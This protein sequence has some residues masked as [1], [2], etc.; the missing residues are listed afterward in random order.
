MTI[1]RVVC[2]LN[3]PD[4]C[5]MLVDIDGGHIKS[6][7]GDP[8][9]PVTRGVVCTKLTHYSSVA[10]SPER[11]KTPQKRAGPKGSGRFVPISWNEAADLICDQIRAVS[12]EYT[13][14]SILP[15]TYT[16]TMGI[17]NRYALDRFFHAINASRLQRSICVDGAYA[18]WNVTIGKVI[19]TDCSR[20]KD[21]DL[22]VL[23]GI[24]AMST[25][26]HIMPFVSAARAKGARLIVIDPYRNRTAAV[27]DQHIKIRPGT[28]AA[29]ALGVMHVLI[30]ENLID[31]NYIVQ[32]TLGFEELGRRIEEYPPSR[33]SKITGMTA[34]EIVDFAR[35]YGR[36]RAPFL[37]I[38][39]GLSRN[40]N[41]GM[42]VRTIACLPGLVGAFQKPGGGCFLASGG[43][44]EL[45]TEKLQRPDLLMKQ[46]RIVNMVQL[47]RALTELDPPIKLLYVC[48]SNP[49]TIAPN[50]VKILN[51]LAREDLF[52]VVHDQFL[53][54]TARFADV[55]LPAPTFLEYTDW[56]R[57]YGHYYIQKSPA[58]MA[59]QGD[60]KTNWEA[61]SFLAEKLGLTEPALFESPEEIMQGCLRPE[62]QFMRGITMEALERGGPVRAQI[63]MEGDPFAN[64]FFTPSGKMEFYSRSL[65]DRGMDPL[66]AHIPT[67]E[68]L[69]N[70]AL[71]ERYPLHLLTPPSHFFLNSQCVVGAYHRRH[72]G[73][74]TVKITSEDADARGVKNGDLV[75]VYNERGEC[76]LYAEVTDSVQ[77][78]VVVAEAGWWGSFSPGGKSV[79][80]LTTDELTDLG[81]SAAFH[82]G[83]VELEIA[84][85]TGR[86]HVED[87]RN[88]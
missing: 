10:E 17:V 62:S 72:Q 45:D 35:A 28:D 57:S 43:A 3:C 79:N 38:G 55:L 60:T 80:H 78:N 1:S 15:Y 5:S 58:V 83:L 76:L 81:E 41:G 69:E 36:A 77:P 12:A 20:M 88:G 49:A 65:A 27:A 23:W 56:Y 48:A 46:T 13:P 44:W 16:G 40:L 18:G 66:P 19:G 11:L 22:I 8:E 87:V 71:A 59:R 47:G 31:R 2:P 53:T 68:G 82:T 4:T 74:P 14:E 25:N 6:I 73:R 85:E 21:A 39:L 7:R 32:Y 30:S 29:L 34:A 9:H 75:R 64:G 42:M 86:G 70:P 26:M 67:K 37:R 50:S 33:V 61:V 84:T 54:D 52:T 63:P 24:N 51:G